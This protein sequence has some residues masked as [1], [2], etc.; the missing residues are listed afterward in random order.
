MVSYLIDSSAVNAGIIKICILLK[1]V[2]QF[3]YLGYKA[4]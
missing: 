1:L 4:G 2:V 3:F